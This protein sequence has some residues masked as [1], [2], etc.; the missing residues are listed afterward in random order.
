MHDKL[1]LLFQ[2][3]KRHWTGWTETEEF[4]LWTCFSLSLVWKLS[5]SAWSLS[6]TVLSSSCFSFSL[7]I[8]SS[9]IPS[10]FL[11][12][13]CFGPT[14]CSK[15]WQ[16]TVTVQQNMVF[17]VWNKHWLY[18]ETFIKCI[19][20]SKWFSLMSTFLF[21]KGMNQISQRNLMWTNNLIELIKMRTNEALSKC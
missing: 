13:S 1:F 20:A 18:K 17:H 9:R 21:S 16:A 11:K 10:A 19:H 12:L 15:S 5:S 2:R 14:T 4:S 6:V 7:L 8:C 3:K